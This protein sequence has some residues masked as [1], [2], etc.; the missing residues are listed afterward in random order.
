MNAVGCHIGAHSLRPK[1]ERRWSS[2]CG[3]HACMYAIER[4]SWVMVRRMAKRNLESLCQ[5]FRVEDVGKL[6]QRVGLRRIVPSA[7]VLRK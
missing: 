7:G 3:M 5:L 4:I 1:G 6:R 2:A